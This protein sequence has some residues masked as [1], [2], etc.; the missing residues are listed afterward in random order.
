[1]HIVQ[2]FELVDERLETL[3]K[4]FIRNPIFDPQPLSNFEQQAAVRQALTNAS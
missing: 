2:S 4:R 1:M 3:G